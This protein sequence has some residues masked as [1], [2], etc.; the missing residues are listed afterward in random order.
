MTRRHPRHRRRLV[1]V[2]T[3][4]DNTEPTY[5]DAIKRLQ[6]RYAVKVDDR[7]GQPS[8]LVTLAIAELK[9][10]T[11][12][13]GDDGGPQDESPVVWCVF[14]RDDHP[15]VDVSVLRATKAGVKVAFSNPCFEVWLLWH[16]EAYGS[17]E[18][19]KCQRL[20]GLIDDRHIRGYVRRGKTL[21]QADIAGRLET[22]TQRATVLDKQHE[23]DGIHQPTQRTPSSNVWE[24]VTSLGIN[25]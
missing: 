4:G 11:A 20:A 10:L 8:E 24:F 5:V 2:F 14:D 15:D 19:G 6:D 16:F 1:R 21:A 7:H 9:R 17:P 3:E 25:Y 12:Q 13:H 23:R 18:S 22:A